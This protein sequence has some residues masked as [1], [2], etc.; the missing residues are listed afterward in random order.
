LIK[1]IIPLVLSVTI[2]CGG[3]GPIEPGPV[4]ND[5]STMQVGEVRVLAP[6]DIRNGI[7]IPSVPDAREFILIVGNTSNIG[8]VEAR[9]LVSGNLAPVSAR[10]EQRVAFSPRLNARIGELDR[11]EPP[12]RLLE[13][14]IRGFER[15]ALS[16]R[17]SLDLLALSGPPLRRSTHAG[18]V[19]VPGDVI[20]L[21]IPDGDAANLCETYFTTEAVVASVSARAIIAVDVIDGPPSGL[22]SQA[23]FDA[24]SAEFDNITY[25]TGE[26]YFGTPTDI[27]DNDRIIILYTGRVNQLTPPSTSSSGFVSGFFFA[28][29]F[30]PPTG[31]PTQSCPQSNQAEIFYLLVPDPSGTKYGNSHSAAAV[32]QITRGTMAHEFQHMINAGRRYTDRVAEE[33]ETIWIEEG[34]AHFAEDAVGRR[35]RG[36]GDLQA[37]SFLD[38]LPDETARNDFNA[39]FVQNLGRFR[40]WMEAPDTSSGI[41]SAAG[42]NLS[43]RGAAFALIRYAADN[44]SNSDPRAFTRR[45]AAGPDTGITNF[46]RATG[47]PLDTVLAGWLVANYA[48]DL[49][50]V[51]VVNARTQYRSY[52]LRS[53]MPPVSAD[54]FPL[55]VEAVGGTS[56]VSGTNRT[57]TGTY[58]R[59][60]VAANAGARNV[61]VTDANGAVVSFAGAHVY[62]LRTQ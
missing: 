16:L 61:K 31:T 39:F 8:D 28:G 34:L 36:F 52:N 46:N 44:F 51:P 56:S 57:G 19:P 25:P 40:R 59:L 12:Q 54:V 14:R 1:R 48:D 9:Y 18:T 53:V 50:G 45:L 30:F 20:P 47:A 24:I 49:A 32:R 60:T 5:L 62:V 21:K 17:S 37:L 4:S 41:S 15:K 11:Q 38:I 13:K 43:S 7:E 55:K 29:D 27:D 42:E 2:A 10:A 58:Y 35:V 33:F 22:F 3:D 23:D 26:S 6:R